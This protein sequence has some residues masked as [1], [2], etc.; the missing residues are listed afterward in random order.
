M[1]VLLD[2]AGTALLDEALAQ[3]FDE[4][5]NPGPAAPAP[6]CGFAID[7]RPEE[8]RQYPAGQELATVRNAGLAY[9]RS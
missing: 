2:E 7:G 1:A 4:A 8:A 3:L 5:G 6:P 9:V